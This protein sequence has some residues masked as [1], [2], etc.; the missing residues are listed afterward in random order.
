MKSF[1]IMVTALAAAMPVIVPAADA[2]G[3][4]VNDALVMAT[5]GQLWSA[6]ATLTWGLIGVSLLKAA[7]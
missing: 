3:L 6:I 4:A 5:G 2:A 1:F 7:R